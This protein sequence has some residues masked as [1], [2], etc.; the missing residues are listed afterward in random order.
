MSLLLVVILIS[1]LVHI[2]SVDYMHLDPFFL[3]FISYLS[4][5]TFFM[6]IL[7]TAGNF[8]QLFLGWEGVGLASY[9]LINFWFTR[10]QANKSA[11][12]AVIVNRIGDFCLY[13][14]ILL[15]FYNF[16]TL[17]FY[18]IFSN[19]YMFSHTCLVFFGFKIF[20]LDLIS[21]FLFFAAM[22]KSAQVGLH[23]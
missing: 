7:V 1:C 18:V 6:L 14:A 21:F 4:L 11:L 9:L 19:I 17:D 20:L 8:F 15:I 10:E 13:F 5:F 2:F 3:K 23:T 16:K 22:G 12:K